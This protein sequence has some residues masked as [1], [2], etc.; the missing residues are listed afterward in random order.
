[1]IVRYKQG[2]KGPIA[3]AKVYS[4]QEHHIDSK[5]IDKD[6]LQVIDKLN[7]GGFETYLVGGAIRDLMLNKNPKDFDVVTSASP[8]QIHRLFFNSRII[9]RRFKIVHVTFGEKIIEVSTFRSINDHAD[10]YENEFGTIEEDA[11]RRDFSINSLY[12]DPKNETILDF[13]N[14]IEDFNLKRISSIIPLNYTFIEDPVRM[15]RAIKYHVTT[16]FKL[17]RGIVRA[18][19]RNGPNLGYVSTSRMT[20]EVNKILYSGSSELIFKELIKYRLFS[21]LLPCMSVYAKSPQF[22]DSMH[23]LDECVNKY[24]NSNKKQNFDRSILYYYLAVPFVIVNRELK[25]PVE[26]YKDVFRQVKV[27]IC[28][29]TPPNFE[30]ERACEQILKTNG[31]KYHKPNKVKKSVQP[32]KKHD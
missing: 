26:I 19:K 32:S 23:K 24:K 22:F 29:N 27:M 21:Y 31:I 25:K 28:P 17:Q 16:G 15:I 13:N 9:G 14:A 7:R 11:K 18:I 12:Y 30:L 8:R 2:S 20:E 1:M 3:V 6:A 4:K 10:S 5:K